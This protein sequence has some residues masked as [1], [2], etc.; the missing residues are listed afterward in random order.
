MNPMLGLGKSLIKNGVSFFSTPQ[1]TPWTPAF[2][3][4]AVW[5]D[6]NDAS[7]ITLNGSTISQWNDKSGNNRH[8]SQATVANQP[9]YTPNGLSGKPVLTFTG[10]NFLSKINDTFLQNAPAVS[11]FSVVSFADYVTNRRAIDMRTTTGKVARLLLLGQASALQSAGRRLSADSLSTRNG[12]AVAANQPAIVGS[13]LNFANN[14]NTAVVNGV[15]SPAATFSSGAGNSEDALVDFEMGT[16]VTTQLFLGTMA[17]TV[18]VS[19]I[20]SL[21]DRQR[22]EGYLAWKWDLVANLPSGHPYKNAAPTVVVWT[23][24]QITTELWLDAN[25]S[26]TITLNGSNVSQWRD[27]SGNSRHVSQATAANQPI[28]TATG[29]NGKPVLTFGG[30]Q[31]LNGTSPELANQTNLNF[32]GVS[33][34]TSRTYA[35]GF[36]SGGTTNPTSG[37]RWGLFGNGANVGDGIGWAGNSG[38]GLGNGLLL[39]ASTPFQSSY[40]K[41]PTNWNVFLNGTVISGPIADTSSPT[42]TFNFRIGAEMSNA[43]YAASAVYGEFVVTRGAL[44]TDNRQRLEGYL[45][46]KWGL[47][48]N[49]PSGHPYKNSPPTV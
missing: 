29:L 26:S 13:Q 44:S 16:S 46:W 43:Q 2:I 20:L 8:V 38:T 47:E 36:G 14:S 42:G 19:G 40:I 30:N 22:L 32:F 37:I 24:A 12:A 7:T 18:F 11:V 28:Y 48:A 17:E 27:K 25:D 41:T 3:S 31:V 5:L 4:T 23:P 39:P 34:I 33:I 9:T 45:A 49:L 1:T 6:A 15:V 10:T 21:E 35:V